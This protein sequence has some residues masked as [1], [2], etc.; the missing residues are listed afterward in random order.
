MFP[1]VIVSFGAMVAF[2]QKA[3]AEV[4]QMKTFRI[5][6]V[7]VVLVGE[8]GD[9]MYSLIDLVVPAGTVIVK[10]VIDILSGVPELGEFEVVAVTPV[11]VVPSYT[12]KIRA[13]ELL[14]I[15]A[16]NDIVF[17]VRLFPAE[18]VIGNSI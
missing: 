5:F 18:A 2:A 6:K 3:D 12:L 14:L 16:K 8:A 1:A 13:P 11:D 15:Q 7:L 10:P 17:T 4:P 9:V